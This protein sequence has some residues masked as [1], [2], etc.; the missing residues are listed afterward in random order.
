MCWSD[1]DF[2]FVHLAFHPC[3]LARS[4]IDYR[5][6]ALITDRPEPISAHS[7]NYPKGVRVHRDVLSWEASHLKNAHMVVLEHDLVSIRI[8]LS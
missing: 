4:P 1:E 3:G 2:G 8:D 6:N 5:F 7:D